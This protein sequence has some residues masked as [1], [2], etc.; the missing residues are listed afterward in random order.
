MNEWDYFFLIFHH[1]CFETKKYF[2]IYILCFWLTISHS[3][4]IVM[5]TTI[6]VPREHHFSAI[7]LW[8]CEWNVLVIASS[9]M[10]LVYVS[11]WTAFWNKGMTT[12]FK[13]ENLLLGKCFC[14]KYVRGNVEW[15]IFFR[16]VFVWKF[17]NHNNKFSDNNIQCCFCYH[18]SLRAKKRTHSGTRSLQRVNTK[19]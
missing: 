15:L 12:A 5:V 8:A 16:T 2:Q 1:A 11:A 19:I 17:C 13:S 10:W 6:F 4:S 14:V 3:F 18:N 7:G 9:C